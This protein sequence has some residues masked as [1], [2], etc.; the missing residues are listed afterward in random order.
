MKYSYVVGP[1]V[2]RAIQL[3]PTGG[4]ANHN[5]LRLCVQPKDGGVKVE[6]RVRL[7]ESAWDQVTNRLTGM[8]N[9]NCGSFTQPC[10]TASRTLL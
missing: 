10:S 2:P 9:T 5:L 3:C 7:V 6:G 1:F 8:T 4:Q